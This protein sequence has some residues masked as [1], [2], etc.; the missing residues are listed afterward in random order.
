MKDRILRLESIKESCNNCIKIIIDY[1]PIKREKEL[2]KV[3]E[4]LYGEK[5]GNK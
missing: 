1:I 5:N 3:Y 4:E 2:Y